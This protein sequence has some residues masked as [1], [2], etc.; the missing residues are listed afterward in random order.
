MQLKT[1]GQPLPAEPYVQNTSENGQ[2]PAYSCITGHMGVNIG[3]VRVVKP[4][5]GLLEEKLHYA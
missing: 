1:E 4:F 5:V 2:R 3:P